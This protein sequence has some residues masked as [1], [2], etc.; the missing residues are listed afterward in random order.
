MKRPVVLLTVALSA[1]PLSAMAQIDNYK[2]Y[3]MLLAR[4]CPSKRLELVSP[5]DL[6]VLIDDFHDSLPANEKNRMDRANDTK[7]VCAKVIAGL[8]CGNVADLRAMTK[9]GLLVNFAKRVCASGLVCKA[10][11]ECAKS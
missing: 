7:K 3:H 10:Q 9:V 5:A 4:N 8:T 1:F 6:N 11:S 2:P